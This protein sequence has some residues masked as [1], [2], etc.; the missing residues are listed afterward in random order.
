MNKTIP[1]LLRLLLGVLALSRGISREISP[2]T[3]MIRDKT[4][5]VLVGASVPWWKN[6][7]ANLGEL[8]STV[9]QLRV[10]RTKSARW[11]ATVGF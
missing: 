2:L 5:A 7:M 9:S 4:S 10:E 8:A 3:R 6:F 1:K 11:P